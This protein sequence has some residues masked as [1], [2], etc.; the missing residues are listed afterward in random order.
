MTKEFVDNLMLQEPEFQEIEKRR[1]A[2][3]KV[4][5]ITYTHTQL[6]DR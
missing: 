3:S 4:S 1:A 2:I 5:T 6:R